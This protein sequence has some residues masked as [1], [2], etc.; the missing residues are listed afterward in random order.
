M[1][2]LDQAKLGYYYDERHNDESMM[3]WIDNF[4]FFFL[5]NIFGLFGDGRW[6]RGEKERKS[7]IRFH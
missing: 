5:I 3:T 7:K 2:E 1:D 4:F 6:R